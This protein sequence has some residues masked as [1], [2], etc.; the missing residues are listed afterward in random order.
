M[1]LN[2]LHGFPLFAHLPG[3]LDLVAAEIR[4]QDP[5]IVCLQE[6]P[7][8]LG[9]AARTLARRTGLNYLYL[10]ANGN[11]RALLFEEGEVILSR[12]PLRD[13]AAVELMP[14][15]GFFEHRVALAAT[16]I[17]PWGEVRVY[18]SHLTAGDPE[19]N[20]GQAASLA[21]LVA[22]DPIRPA[23]VAGDFNAREETPQIQALDWIDAY[24]TAH[25]RDEGPTCCIKD[26]TAGPG[27]ALEKRIDY[28]FLIPGAD[29]A[30]VVSG[31]RVFDEPYRQGD[32]WLWASDHAGLMAEIDLAPQG[33]E[34]CLLLP[35]EDGEQIARCEA[36]LPAQG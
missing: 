29:G 35:G 32:G 21:A 23:L 26:L 6:V 11:R 17:T 9:S 18:V 31:R 13:A 25:P 36:W 12:F 30:E 4:R 16:A 27:E 14:R 28:V 24:R 5:D 34:L 2:V 15:A 3:R 1:S 10:R 33:Q 19:I 7:W 22:G 8:H 20:R